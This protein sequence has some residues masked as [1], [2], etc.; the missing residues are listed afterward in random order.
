MKTTRRK[1]TGPPV[2][3]PFTV[4]RADDEDVPVPQVGPAYAPCLIHG[5]RC[6]LLYWTVE[7]WAALTP[8]RN[9]PKETFPD[10][11]HGGQFKVFELP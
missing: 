8:D 1:R 11:R 5:R 4:F 2:V 6:F 9:R 3:L 10:M 7:E